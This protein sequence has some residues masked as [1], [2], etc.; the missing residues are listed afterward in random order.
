VRSLAS[1]ICGLIAGWLIITEPALIPSSWKNEIG[2]FLAH[3]QLVDTAAIK[4]SESSAIATK[5]RLAIILSSIIPLFIY[6]SVATL[7]FLW[8][9]KAREIFYASLVYPI[10]TLS[11]IAIISNFS[12]SYENTYQPYI[13]NPITYAE[14]YFLNSVTFIFFLYTLISIAKFF[15]KSRQ[16]A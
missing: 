3:N 16:R 7:I 8:S 15:N 14:V 10:Y 11:S 5:Y 1:I 4:L 9:N 13:R 12:T 2:Q 6:A